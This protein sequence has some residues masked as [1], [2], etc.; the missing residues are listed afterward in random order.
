MPH[1]KLS[2][3]GGVVENETQALN[4]AAISK[5]NRIRFRPDPQGLSLPEKIGGWAKFWANEIGPGPPAVGI[6][7]TLWAYMDTGLNQWLGYG[8]DNGPLYTSPSE[9][10]VLQCA[11]TSGLTTATTKFKITPYW[12]S[13]AAL[14][15]F[16]TTAASNLVNVHDNTL[17][18]A[19]L[20]T[21]FTS[22]YLTT[23][24]SVGGI[25]ISAG[26]YQIVRIGTGTNPY[27]IVV[28]DIFNNPLNAA[29]S[30]VASA[31]TITGVTFSGGTPNTLTFSWSSPSYT[32]PVGEGF[33]VVGLTPA[34]ADGSYVATGS[35][36]T[37]VTAA[38]T[39]GSYTYGSG[40]SL[41]NYGFIPQ[42]S[43]DGTTGSITV[44]LPD[45]GQVVGAQWTIL[46]ETPVANVNLYGNYIVNSVIS[47]SQFTI[48]AAMLS[49]AASTQSQ[50]AFAIT[51]GTGNGTDVTL[52][53]TQ[54]PYSSHLFQTTSSILVAGISGGL[55]AWNGP[56]TVLSHTTATVTFANTTS[57]TWV[58]ADGGSISDIRGDVGLIYSI[59][60]E[61]G[62]PPGGNY[63]L[64]SSMIWAMDNWGDVLLACPSQSP[65]I[66]YPNITVYFQPI[67]FWDFITNQGNLSA[68]ALWTAPTANNGFFVAMPQRQIVAWGST[69]NGVI[70]PLLV[71]WCDVNNYLTWT[72]QI[73]NQA[74][75]FR[76]S[77]GA[78]IVAGRQV[79]Q[80]GLLWTDVEL[81]A[82]QYEGQ[83]YV[84]GFNKIG[85]GC[86]LI[87]EHAHCVLNGIVYWMGKSQ[88]FMLTSE[89]V[90]PIPCPVWDIAFQDLDPVNIYRITAAAN[91]MSQEVTWYFPVQ[92]GTGDNSI[93]VKYNTLMGIWDYG[94]LDRS[95]WVDVSIL[96]QPIGFSPSLL[97]VY[98][99][100]ISP[101]ADGAA[102]GETFTT[103]W[104]AI[105]EGDNK[106]TIDQVWPDFQWG[107]YGVST[108]ANINITFNSTSYPTS[109]APAYTYGPYT[110]TD[111]GTTFISPRIRDRLISITISGIGTGTWWRLGAVRYRAQPD[112]KY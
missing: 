60:Y 99:H 104:F 32:I 56:Q 92:G 22:V 83:P 13:C 86:G 42:Y 29:Y 102:M 4:Q 70:D 17:G 52:T 7:R 108:A 26:M 107:Y 37:S 1:A 18:L 98:Q 82:M 96:Q 33:S 25:L 103:G 69:F 50:N 67:Y 36:T 73:T 74:G 35:T 94:T 24:V 85:Q 71:R 23:P 75:S 105:A 110:V 44:T 16:Q 66:Q 79:F 43:S 48:T 2:L 30:T 3:V 27:N 57:G 20:S 34:A 59:P 39:L 58:S 64:V 78:Q 112:G 101:D 111:A 10:G 41:T 53:F 6:I 87:A 62:S 51:A 80:Q 5:S 90:Q 93:Y 106:A 88:F 55:A 14:T 84:Y 38:T 61:L 40:G 11:E 15:N 68:Q 89:G 12:A 28:N 19:A 47:A 72:A 95:A 77:S 100:E 81:W 46:N 8:T 45:H 65:A 21:G 31:I 91:S 9:L 97:Y 63:L 49:T 76:L 109:A 54:T